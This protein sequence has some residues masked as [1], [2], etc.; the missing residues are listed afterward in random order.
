MHGAIFVM[1]NMAT[2]PQRTNRAN[3]NNRANKTY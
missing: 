1:T 3:K 2:E